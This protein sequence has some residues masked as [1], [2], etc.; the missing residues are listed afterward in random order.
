MRWR[1]RRLSGG[2][3]QF[4][5]RDSSG[6][7]DVRSKNAD[8]GGG[9]GLVQVVAVGRAVLQDVA[10]FHLLVLHIVH[11]GKSLAFLIKE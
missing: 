1:S 7:L 6:A 2:E 8:G 3:A 4:V 11:S 5:D 10:W 9:A